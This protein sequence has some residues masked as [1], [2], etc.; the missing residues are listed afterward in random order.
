MTSSKFNILSFFLNSSY[1][2]SLN[3]RCFGGFL[4]VLIV[5]QMAAGS[6]YVTFWESGTIVP[7]QCLGI[8]V[9]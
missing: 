1:L 8:R 6:R 4:G 2:S 7:E 3:T 5:S 9:Y